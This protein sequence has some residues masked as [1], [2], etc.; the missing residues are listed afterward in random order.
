L[1]AP[2]EQPT[3]DG[4]PWPIAVRAAEAL[5]HGLAQQFVFALPRQRF[6][7]RSGHR[8]APDLGS[9]D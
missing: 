1:P 4:P 9:L 3:E 7:Q 6:M 8:G 2:G 5:L